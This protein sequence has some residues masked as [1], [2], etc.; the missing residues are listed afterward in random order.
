[1]GADQ[2]EL[3]QRL[4]VTVG[5]TAIHP[6]RIGAATDEI[7]QFAAAVS[8]ALLPLMREDNHLV[9]THGDNPLVAGML[10]QHFYA[11]E[12]VPAARFDMYVALAQGGVGYY[13]RQALHNALADARHPR[14]V[15]SVLTEVEVDAADA[16]FSGPGDPVG[17]SF[18]E[19]EARLLAAC[20]WNM[21]PDAAR[22]WRLGV[23]R[24]RPRSVVDLVEIDALMRSGA[25]VIA[26]GGG[27]IPVVRSE[28]GVRAG[29]HAVLDKD[30]SAA[31]LANALG[32]AHLLIL[33]TVSRV[34]IRFRKPAERW[35]DAVNA[36]ELAG[37][38]A[39]GHF[40]ADSMG[41]KIDAALQFLA[42]G[43]K[44]VVIAHLNEA[45]AALRGET[46][47]HIVP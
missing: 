10:M 9:V 24:P 40:A 33:T 34:A 28:L 1:V 20:G 45:A 30:L 16:A 11:R 17:P 37:Y 2:G 43:G 47:T 42:G 41:P 18:T 26:A 13:L 39:E 12:R 38:R 15:T 8:S 22:G 14:R 25:V 27:G 3:P 32:I 19:E 4:L 36:A 46:G 29:V 23:P 21:Q 6:D 44:R 7:M 31:L 35:L 5:G